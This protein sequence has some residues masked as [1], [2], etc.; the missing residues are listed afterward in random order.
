MRFF[1]SKLKKHSIGEVK[2]NTASLKQMGR[3]VVGEWKSLGKQTAK[4]KLLVFDPVPDKYS[5]ITLE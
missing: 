1:C 5:N 3:N 4:E 2:N